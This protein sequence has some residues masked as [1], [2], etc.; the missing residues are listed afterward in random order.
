MLRYSGRRNKK[1]PRLAPGGR[2]GE[3]AYRDYRIIVLDIVLST[4]NYSLCKDIT[5]ASVQR[6]YAHRH[7]YSL[8]LREI[9]SADVGAKRIVSKAGTAPERAQQLCA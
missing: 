4:G 9:Q 2:T 7:L 6:Y 1:A 8:S 5:A 3:P